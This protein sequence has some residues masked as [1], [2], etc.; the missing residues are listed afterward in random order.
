MPFHNTIIAQVILECLPTHKDGQSTDNFGSPFTRRPE[1]LPDVPLLAAPPN[2]TAPTPT[3]A[4]KAGLLVPDLLPSRFAW[5]AGSNAPSH[6]LAPSPSSS[7]SK[8]TTTP[9]PYHLGRPHR[10]TGT[11]RINGQVRPEQIA[12][13][14]TLEWNLR[15]LEALMIHPPLSSKST[16]LPLSTIRR[17]ATQGLVTPT[18]SIPRLVTSANPCLQNLTMSLS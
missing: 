12:T 1:R 16:S 15:P 2:K 5:L 11:R 6:E 18:T 17:T 3:P 7:S 9:P 8:L 13:A 14:L 4:T 10:P